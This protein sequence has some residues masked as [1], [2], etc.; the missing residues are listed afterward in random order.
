ML[1]QQISAFSNSDA[2]DALLGIVQLWPDTMHQVSDLQ[3]EHFENFENRLLWEA[4]LEMHIDGSDIG[5]RALLLGRLRSDGILDQLGGAVR[6]AELCAIPV[7]SGNLGTYVT[8]IKTKRLESLAVAACERFKSKLGTV[9]TLELIE[10]LRGDLSESSDSS[11]ELKG[12]TM[13]E[14]ARHAMA[15]VDDVGNKTWQTGYLELDRLI[16]G[17]MG[18]N[19][20]TVIAAGPSYG[21][22]AMVLN[23]MRQGSHDGKPI[24]CLYVGMEMGESELFDRFVS[25]DGRIP[26]QIARQLRLNLADKDSWKSYGH[27][28]GQ[29][30][31]RIAKMGH[32]IK[33]DGLVTIMQFRAL[34]ARYAGEIDCAV[35]DYIQQLKPTSPGQSDM[36]KINE[37]SWSCKDLAMTYNIPIIA[38]SQLNRDGYKDG[39]KPTLANLRASGQLEQDADNV[40]MLWREKRDGAVTEPIEVFL[41]KNRSGPVA[42][43]GLEFNGSFG[44]ISNQQAKTCDDR[45][46]ADA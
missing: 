30:V 46:F 34:V 9:G 36:E 5:D 19:S 37:A 43:L 25:A 1:N 26:S 13:K 45:R 39:C 2:E 20:Y 6:L 44:L 18:R 12:R 10:R 8:L 17:Q 16:G 22:T 15:E 24:R 40:W 21:K 11:V 4:L 3:L 7:N 31:G 38:L 41:A 14:V 35:I 42:R 28:F 33:S 23:L 32:I 29:T 27:A